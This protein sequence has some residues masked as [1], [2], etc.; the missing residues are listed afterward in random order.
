MQKVFWV[1]IVIIIVGFIL[2]LL[3]ETGE[4][5]IAVN[6]YHGPSSIDIVGLSLIILCWAMMLVTAIKRYKKI[7]GGLNSN[8]FIIW[9]AA[10][11][12]G[13]IWIVISLFN[14]TQHA[15]ITGA[16]IAIAG[17]AFLF[18]VVYKKE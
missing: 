13:T 11:I 9:V 15:W 14:N 5:L 12:I 16:A 2:L 4:V 10:I 7:R 3:P 8:Q 18:Y 17:Y 1:Y 6:D